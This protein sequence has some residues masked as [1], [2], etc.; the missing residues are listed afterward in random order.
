MIHI[1]SSDDYAW[2]EDLY[3]RVDRRLGEKTKAGAIDGAYEFTEQ[4]LPNLERA[5]DHPDMTPELA[6]TLSTQKVR[7]D[8]RIETDLVIN[9][10]E[11]R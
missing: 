7:L 6:E 11:R 3:D 5:L 2:R 9:G 10:D 8:Y 1:K 4:M